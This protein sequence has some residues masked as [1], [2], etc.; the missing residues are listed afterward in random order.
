MFQQKSPKNGRKSADDVILL[1]TDWR[2]NAVDTAQEIADADY[3][4]KV[5]KNEKK[6][7]IIGVA[8][9]DVSSY[10]K[11]F[12]DWADSPDLVFETGLAKLGMEKNVNILVEQLKDPLCGNCVDVEKRVRAVTIARFSRLY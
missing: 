7:K 10:R 1:F 6:I 11:N 3:Y 4:S 12:Q 9:G 2:P 5:L 8:A